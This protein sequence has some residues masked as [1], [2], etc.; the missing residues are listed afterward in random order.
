MMINSSN[1]KINN[2]LNKQ[3]LFQ[4]YM[5]KIVLI[6]IL[7]ILLIIKLKKMIKE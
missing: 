1:Y 7:M 6:K 3:K 2:V 4:F 5:M